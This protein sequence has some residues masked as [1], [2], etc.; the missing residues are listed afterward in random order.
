MARG[1]DEGWRRQHATETEER[2][3]SGGS[4]EEN[5]GRKV[6]R[7]GLRGNALERRSAMGGA[8]GDEED[9]G[10]GGPVRLQG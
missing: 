6:M 4:E 2:R 8:A 7:T 10:N 5:K 9:G 1:G 3:G